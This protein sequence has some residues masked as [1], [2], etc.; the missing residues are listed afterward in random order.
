MITYVFPDLDPT[1]PNIDTDAHP[2]LKLC[3]SIDTND[4]DEDEKK[5]SDSFEKK[6]EDEV[7]DKQRKG[8]YISRINGN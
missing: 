4:P 6:E 8:D 3:Q 7:K 2:E 5:R 1:T